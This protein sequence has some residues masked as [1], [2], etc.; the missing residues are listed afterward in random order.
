[1]IRAERRKFGFDALEPRD[2]AD[3]DLNPYLKLH[4][5]FGPPVLTAA[6]AQIHAGAWS[7]A[8]GRKAPLH[9]EIGSGNGFYLA[10]MAAAHPEWNWLGMEIR[11]KRVV[12]TAR[13]IR[14]AHLSNALI[15]R[16][17]AFHLG[18][19]F[20]PSELDGIH[21][22]HPDPW[23][24]K[25]HGKNRLIS[26]SFAR[27]VAQLLKPGGTLR[28]KTDDRSNLERML[29]VIPG[30]PL[31]MLAMTTDIARHGP[32]WPADDDVITNYERKFRERGLPVLALLLVRDPA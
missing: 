32:P 27:Q 13:K 15:A 16:Y 29:A 7:S 14:R 2:Y 6:Q 18:D 12:L 1:M 9:L 8:F 24:K 21:L 26:A 30:L 17:D 5:R 4:A 20:R 19:L 31:R 10:G 25:R 11:F 28:L 22:N 3:P 23:P